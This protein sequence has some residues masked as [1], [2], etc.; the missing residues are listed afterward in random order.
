[1]VV[2]QWHPVL[3]PRLAQY[4]RTIVQQRSQCIV[5]GLLQGGEIDDRFN[6]GPDGTTGIQCPVKPLIRCPQNSPLFNLALMGY[7]PR[8]WEQ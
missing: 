4:Q 5:L 6:K 1:M 8:E 3:S 2:I 7:I